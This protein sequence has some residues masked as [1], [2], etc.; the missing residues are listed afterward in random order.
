M[1]VTNVQNVNKGPVVL[2]FDLEFTKLNFTVRGF[3]LMHSGD[4]R[5]IGSPCREYQGEDG[6]RKFWPYFKVAQ[7]KEESFQAAV[8]KQLEEHLQ[9][10]APVDPVFDDSNC[11]F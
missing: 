2:S 3:K 11:P 1:I 10:K 5:W 4:R 7:G 9:V 8:C 6:K